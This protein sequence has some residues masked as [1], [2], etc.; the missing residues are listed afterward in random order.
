[1]LA[2]SEILAEIHI[3]DGLLPHIVNASLNISL[4][5]DL[6]LIC[7]L[8]CIKYTYEQ[9]AR[10]GEMR[11]FSRN[12]L[13]GIDHLRDVGVGGGTILKWVLKSVWTC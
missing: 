10:M 13:R 7:I 11:N 3:L 2:L 12:T 9:V 6:I 4:S 5:L 1:V 8:G